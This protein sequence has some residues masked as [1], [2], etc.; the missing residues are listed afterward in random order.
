MGKSKWVATDEL[1]L[2]YVGIIK[3]GSITLKRGQGKRW[4]KPG[5]KILNIENEGNGFIINMER[6]KGLY[7]DYGTAYD[8]LIALKMLNAGDKGWANEPIKVKRGK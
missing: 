7:V 5:S 1:G 4:T 6:H 8:L 3:D 2:D